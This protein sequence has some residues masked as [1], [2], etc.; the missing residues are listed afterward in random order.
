MINTKSF[1]QGYACAV[2]VLINLHGSM[3]EAEDV[4]K[5]NFS[6][7]QQLKDNDIDPFDIE[8]LEPIMKEIER[9]RKPK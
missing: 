4:M 5:E 3:T 8:R 2:S 7:L 1:N 9:K 6:S